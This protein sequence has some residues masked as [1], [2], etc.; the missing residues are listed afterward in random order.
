[1]GSREDFGRQETT[2]RYAVQNSVPSF[3]VKVNAGEHDIS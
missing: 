3:A 1:M 2:Y